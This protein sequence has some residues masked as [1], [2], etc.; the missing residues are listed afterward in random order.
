MCE[1]CEALLK[2]FWVNVCFFRRSNKKSPFILLLVPGIHTILTFIFTCATFGCYFL[3]WR[4]RGGQQW[5]ADHSTGSLLSNTLSWG[6]N[7]GKIQ[8]ILQP[9]EPAQNGPLDQPRTRPPRGH[10]QR[11]PNCRQVCLLR[12]SWHKKNSP[13]LQVQLFHRLFAVDRHCSQWSS[14]GALDIC[15]CVRPRDETSDQTDSGGRGGG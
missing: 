11:H 12:Q 9:T 1:S 7:G 5:G 3:R 4:W 14:H 10:R 13:E 2:Y 8:G 6:D 15:G